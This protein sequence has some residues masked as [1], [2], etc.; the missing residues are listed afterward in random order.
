MP[1]SAGRPQQDIRG[2]GCNAIRAVVGYAS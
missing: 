2:A 1:S